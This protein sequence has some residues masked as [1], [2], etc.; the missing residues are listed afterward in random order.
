MRLLVLDLSTFTGFCFGTE[1]GVIEHGTNALPKTGDDI[2]WFLNAH[3][4]WLDSTISRFL[5]E[6]IAFESPILPGTTNLNTCRKLYGLCGVTE[7]IARNRRI[8]CTEAN[9]MD[10]RRHFIGCARAPKDVAAK[11]RRTWMKD[12]TV[13]MCRRRGFRPADDNDADALA[14]FSY[15]MSLRSQGFELLG[16]EIPRAA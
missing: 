3:W 6:E 14:L 1:A 13:T 10:I 15:V 16:D 2:G 12:S 8:T 11:D 7:M 5:P 9:L 4:C